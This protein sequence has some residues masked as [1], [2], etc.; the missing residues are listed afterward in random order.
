MTRDA[1]LSL[2]FEDGERLMKWLGRVSNLRWKVVTLLV[3]PITFVMTLDRAAMTVAAPTIQKEF[4]LTIVE[5]SLILTVYFWTYA[6]GQIP[7]GRMAE[8]KGSRK[9]LFSTSVLWSIMMMV[10]PL[11]STFNWLFGCRA[12]LGGANDDPKV[13]LQ[14]W[15]SNP[16]GDN[17][18]PPRSNNSTGVGAERPG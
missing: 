12:I 3:A 14:R 18:I 7:A 8:D 10:T 2:Y 1:V 16:I 9:V 5:M 17:S 6:L 13:G 4:G 11:G 15:R